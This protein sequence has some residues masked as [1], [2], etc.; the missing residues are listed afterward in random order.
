MT[1]GIVDTI[2]PLLHPRKLWSTDYYFFLF[3]F[4]VIL[5]GLLLHNPLT[6]LSFLYLKM[7]EIFCNPRTS[8]P[9]IV[10]LSTSASSPTNFLTWAKPTLHFFLIHP[11]DPNTLASVLTAPLNCP[12]HSD[13][14]ATIIYYKSSSCF[15]ALWHLTSFLLET[16][17][18]FISTRNTFLSLPLSQV[19]IP[20]LYIPQML[21]L[22]RSTSQ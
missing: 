2:Y 1:Y 22:P 8:F 3:H 16:F 20:L 17:A 21:M 11:S 14:Q 15:T 7:F 12:H 5:Y 4:N 13:S 10:C 19:Q 9:W 18:F 6:S